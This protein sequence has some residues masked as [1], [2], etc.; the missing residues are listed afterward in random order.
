MKCAGSSIT[1]GIG[2]TQRFLIQSCIDDNMSVKPVHDFFSPFVYRPAFPTRR[3]AYMYTDFVLNSSVST[4]CSTFAPLQ[5][6]LPYSVS[7]NSA[8]NCIQSASCSIS[9]SPPLLVPSSENDVY[10]R[11]QTESIVCL[12]PKEGSHPLCSA[13][14]PNCSV[15]LL[16]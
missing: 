16:H 12:L 4:N 3:F 9:T 14:I 15:T 5:N 7:S 1:S 6:V 10:R 8:C 11:S 2:A 13:V